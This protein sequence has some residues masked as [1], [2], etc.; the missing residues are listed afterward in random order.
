MQIALRRGDILVTKDIF[1]DVD[2]DTARVQPR[3]QGMAKIMEAKIRPTDSGA[4]CF[5]STPDR[6]DA[7]L[8]ERLVRFSGLLVDRGAAHAIATVDAEDK[9][10]PP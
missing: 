7:S 3:P 10:S 8:P 5:K 2:I 9:Y 6:T 4:R 1:N